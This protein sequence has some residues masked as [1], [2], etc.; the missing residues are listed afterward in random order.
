MRAV[1]LGLLVAVG[2]ADGAAA[3]A[4]TQTQRSAEL[5]APRPAWTSAAARACIVSAYR[6]G[7]TRS[8]WPSTAPWLAGSGR[9][10]PDLPPR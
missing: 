9:Y 10:T 4:V 2:V 3:Q 6:H 8:Y 1:L 5:C 7:A